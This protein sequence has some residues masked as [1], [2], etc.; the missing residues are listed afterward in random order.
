MRAE[1]VG[2]HNRRT[3]VRILHRSG[4]ENGYGSGYTGARERIR[5]T[6]IRCRRYTTPSSLLYVVGRAPSALVAFERQQ[7]RMSATG[8]MELSVINHRFHP[9][10]DKPCWLVQPGYGSFLTLEFGAPKLTIREPYATATPVPHAHGSP[11]RRVVRVHGEWH[12][13]I[14]CCHWHVTHGGQLMGDSSTARHRNRAA[15]EL[16]GQI[17]THVTVSPANGA[18]SCTF[19]LGGQLTTTP[20]D[21][22]SEQ[23]LLYEPSGNVFTIRADGRYSHM[24]SMT[25][26]GQEDWQRLRSLC[27]G[28][29]RRARPTRR[30]S[31]AAGSRRF[32]HLDAAR[33]CF[34]SVGV[35]H[36]SRPLNANPLGGSTLYPSPRWPA[37]ESLG[38]SA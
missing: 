8:T 23:W 5:R 18:S 19:D 2:D 38:V 15:Q 25:T 35:I 26:A 21:Q 11:P 14:Y 29:E 6:L 16:D 27:A 12:L 1:V 20:Y 4:G 17:L 22:D 30:C 13:W 31:G 10:R 3:H 28:L 9:L 36:P 7:N 34:R 32:W 37:Y 33:R 24:P